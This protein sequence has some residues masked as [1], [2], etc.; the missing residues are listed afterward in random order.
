MGGGDGWSEGD[1]GVGWG[2]G[3]FTAFLIGR[4]HTDGLDSFHFMQHANFDLSLLYA[5]FLPMLNSRKQWVG[6]GW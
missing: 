2:Y 1:R 5:G 4:G 3:N 6:C